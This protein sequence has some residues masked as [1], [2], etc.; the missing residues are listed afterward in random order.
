MDR[1][2]MDWEHRRI[3]PHLF[4]HRLHVLPHPACPHS[5]KGARRRSSLEARLQVA[6]RASG[7]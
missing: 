2:A 7:D 6:A 3:V 1:R 5:P 4:Y